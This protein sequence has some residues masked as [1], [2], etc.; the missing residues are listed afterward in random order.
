MVKTLFV[1]PPELVIVT[2]GVAPK[3][4]IKM[5]CILAAVAVILNLGSKV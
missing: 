5:V 4:G 3:T 1:P 2:T